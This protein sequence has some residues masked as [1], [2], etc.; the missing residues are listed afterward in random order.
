MQFLRAE[1]LLLSALFR[2]RYACFTCIYSQQVA[3]SF[4]IIRCGIVDHFP[5]LGE[6]RAMAGAIPCVLGTVV[7]EGASKV[8]TAGSGGGNKSYGGFKGID[9]KLRT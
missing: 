4:F 1:G 8:G 3:L 7:F 6:A 9:R 2:Y 5:L